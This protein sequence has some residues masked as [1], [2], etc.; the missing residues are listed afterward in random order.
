MT[1]A[2]SKLKAMNRGAPSARTT[3]ENEPLIETEENLAYIQVC[4]EHPLSTR[5]YRPPRP[6]RPAD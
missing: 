1:K 2:K 4:P 5:P 3:E 6:H